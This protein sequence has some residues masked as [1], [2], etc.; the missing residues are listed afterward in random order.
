MTDFRSV[1]HVQ[2]P[3]PVGA[4]REARRFYEELLGLKEVRDP[5]IDRPGTL[6]FSLG[7][8]RLDLTEGCYTGVAPQ[9]HLAL[10]VSGLD[11][12]ARK[13]VDA[14]VLVDAAS[15]VDA[16]RL[17]VDDPFGNRLELIE[18]EEPDLMSARHVTSLQ[19]AV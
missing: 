19:I 9:A 2:L 1:D 11:A 17:Y 16:H 15:L 7:W 3:I 6:R 13:L 18:P 5:Q 4:A 12:L 10:R 8:Q 14:G